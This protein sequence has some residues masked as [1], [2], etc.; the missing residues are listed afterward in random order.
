MRSRYEEQEPLRKGL[1]ITWVKNV[2][3]IRKV[4]GRSANKVAGVSAIR[5]MQMKYKLLRF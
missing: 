4:G 5:M 3:N 2:V 1:H